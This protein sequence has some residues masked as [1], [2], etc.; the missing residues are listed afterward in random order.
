[1]TELPEPMV[2]AS[3]IKDLEESWRET[4]RIERDARL[5]AVRLKEKYRAE[6]EVLKALLAEKEKAVR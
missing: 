2:K 5:N 3:R 1:M 6:V 4:L